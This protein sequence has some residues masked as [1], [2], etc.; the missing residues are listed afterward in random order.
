MDATVLISFQDGDRIKECSA[1][2]V[3]SKSRKIL[4]TAG[5]CMEIYLRSNEREPQFLSNLTSNSTP[6][7]EFELKTQVPDTISP[8]HCFNSLCALSELEVNY[9]MNVAEEKLFGRFN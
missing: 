7:F 3:A 9:T 4:V 6:M 2:L 8:V 5:H 1:V